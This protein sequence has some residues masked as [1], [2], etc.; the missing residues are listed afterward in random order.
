MIDFSKKKKSKCKPLEL[1]KRKGIFGFLC[2]H[3][4]KKS[5]K[6]KIIKVK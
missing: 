1:I 4:S 6:T 3:F 2:Y 5:N